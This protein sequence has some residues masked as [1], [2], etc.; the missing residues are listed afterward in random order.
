MLQ[1]ESARGVC[2]K[3]K[4]APSREFAAIT[5]NSFPVGHLAEL[6]LGTEG[7]AGAK[8]GRASGK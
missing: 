5:G 1:Q 4:R 2:K 8:A 7:K 6:T 3:K